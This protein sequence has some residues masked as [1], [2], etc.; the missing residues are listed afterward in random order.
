MRTLKWVHT[1]AHICVLPTIPSPF[2][3]LCTHVTSLL[4]L[5]IQQEYQHIANSPLTPWFSK[6]MH[7]QNKFLS[8]W[9]LEKKTTNDTAAHFY[10]KGPESLNKQPAKLKERGKY[11]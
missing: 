4:L 3:T 8:T 7:T 6:G 5:V 11:A 10:C 9:A 2:K 1:K